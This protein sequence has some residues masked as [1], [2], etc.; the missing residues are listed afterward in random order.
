MLGHLYLI[1]KGKRLL[2]DFK[3]SK[4][5]RINYKTITNKNRN[6]KWKLQILYLIKNI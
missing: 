3:C 4:I 6:Y 5:K 1:F 2:S